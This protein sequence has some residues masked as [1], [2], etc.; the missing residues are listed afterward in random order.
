M[1][2]AATVV[3]GLS[4][5]VSAG[6][7]NNILITGYWPPTNNIVRD[8]S[9]SPT[10]NPGGWAGR[11]WE[12][13]GYDIYAHFPEF[14]GMVCCN[15]GK[16][17]GDFE[18]DYQDTWDDFQRLSAELKPVAIITFS[19]ANTSIGWEMEPAARRWRLSGESS[20]P[21]QAVGLYSADYLAPTRPTAP[22][23]VA[24][25]VGT[26]RKS[27]LPMAA[28]EAAI[29]SAMSPSVIDA[30]IPT[31]DPSGPPWG[32]YD[33]GGGFL[34]GYIPY[35]AGWY[36]EDRAD[37]STQFRCV[38]SGHIHVGT[39]LDVQVGEEALIL[40]LRELIEHINTMVSPCITDMNDDGFTDDTDFVLFAAAYE[41]FVTRDGDFTNDGLTDDSDFVIFAEAYEEFV[42]N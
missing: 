23:F 1:C 25:P 30:F 36:Q 37:P 12:G 27:T 21:G 6:N 11:N 13:L 22:E 8:F 17:V 32:G 40:T 33:F 20:P 10:S 15:W 31:F 18:V 28:I 41:T 24:Q 16:G 5:L 26:I 4:G 2:A 35:L 7:T 19:R 14:P 38:A 39:N 29:D 3:A 42:C 9:T 34:S